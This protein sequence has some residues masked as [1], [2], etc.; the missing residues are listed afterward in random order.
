MFFSTLNFS[1]N[2]RFCIF[3]FS[4]SLLNFFLSSLLINVLVN[5]I[6][7]QFL[8]LLLHNAIWRNVVQ[9]AWFRLN[10]ILIIVHD[11]LTRSIESVERRMGR[12]ALS[13]WTE[14]NLVLWNEGLNDWLIVSSHWSWACNRCC[15]GTG[16]SSRLC[17]FY[18]LKTLDFR[19]CFSL[20]T[21]NSIFSWRYFSMNSSL[22]SLKCS[23]HLSFSFFLIQKHFL[24]L[25]NFFILNS[26][27]LFIF[28]WIN[29]SILLIFHFFIHC[30]TCTQFTK[31]PFV[32]S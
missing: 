19:K 2:S 10:T 30:S 32:C 9:I 31:I 21:F 12:L 27:K 24:P 11:S 15:L 26:L 13:R 17:R 28:P 16:W 29:K 7:P 6:V 8:Q 22:S 1:L 3:P 25:S 14:S 20:K 18:F 23:Q 5:V 4:K